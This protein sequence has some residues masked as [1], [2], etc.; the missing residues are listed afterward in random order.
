MRVLYLDLDTLRADHLGCYGYHRQTSPNLDKIANEGMVFTNYYCSDAPCLPSRAAMMSGRYGIHNGAV[1]H[2]GTAADQ[3]LQGI[4]RG[5]MSEADSSALPRIFRK[6][7]MR[8]VLISPF[9]ERHSNFTYYA[10]FTEIHNTGKC[11]MESAEEI[12]PTAMDWLDRNAS[13]D[14]WYLHINYWDAHTPYRAPAEFG[15]PFKDSPLPA[16]LTEETLKKHREHVGPHS[17]RETYMYSGKDNPQASK[18]SRYPG[19]LENM[20]DLKDYIDGY[21]C[22]IAYLDSHIGRILN[23]LEKAGVLEDTMIVVSADHGENLGELGLYGEHGTADY[24]TCRIPLIMRHPGKIKRGT[25]DDLLLNID[26]APTYAELFGQK[27]QAIWDGKSF[28]PLLLGKAAKPREDI[29]ISQCAHVCQRSVRWKNW[30]YMRTYHDGYH[31]FPQEML[32]DLEKDPHE[33]RNLAE[34]HPELCQEGAW[35]LM[36]WHDEMMA[37][38][39][40]GITVDPMRT[41]MAEGGPFHAKGQL[42]DY[43]KRLETS[44]RA[45]AIDELKKRHPAEFKG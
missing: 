29:V 7:G 3:H 21:D 28:E 5:F 14:N 22:G 8:T 42:K 36:R 24:P 19:E 26:L 17:A 32:F 39:A 12:S 1:G 38:Q 16:W 35:R 9:A 33:S 41:V 31:L 30:I 34:E 18:W 37:S 43:C 40:N 23:S 45:F 13:S 2:G 44:G 27:P 25:N 10:G 4:S 20:Q 6:A 11:G 15:N